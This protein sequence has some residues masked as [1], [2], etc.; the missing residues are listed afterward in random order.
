[1]TGLVFV[2]DAHPLD[3]PIAWDEHGTARVGRTRVTLEAVVGQFKQGA[4]PEQIAEDFDALDLADV[5][6]VIA[7][8]L[9]HKG[10]VDEYLRSQD[11][12]AESARAKWEAV[13]PPQVG[14][15]RRLL[16][17]REAALADKTRSQK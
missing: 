16:A 3:M 12:E 6:A 5:Y 8:Y 14:L 10:A 13:Y 17:R 9:R 2:K 1:M 4:T 11:K 15:R 7:Y